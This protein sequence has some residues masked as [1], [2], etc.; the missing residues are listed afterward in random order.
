MNPQERIDE[1]KQCPA[2]ETHVSSLESL[3]LQLDSEL[4][5]EREAHNK[6]RESLLNENQK[7]KELLNRAIEE[8]EWSSSYKHKL[9]AF[10]AHKLAEKYREELAQLATSPEEPSEKDTSTETC[11]SQ[12]DTEWRELGPDEVIQEGDEF[13]QKGSYDWRN[14]GEYFLATYPNAHATY[15]PLLRF[16]TRRQ[17]PKQEEKAPNHLHAWMRLQESINRDISGELQNLRN[18]IK[19]LK[20]K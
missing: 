14:C 16:R 18:E 2:W 8:I 13:N 1:L 15:H 6:T 9:T 10:T 20:Q 11:P 12:K 3:A 17:L 5:R 4:C 7:L 19:K